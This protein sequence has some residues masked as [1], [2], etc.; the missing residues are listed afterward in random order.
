MVSKYSHAAFIIC[1]VPNICL[2]YCVKNFFFLVICCYNLQVKLSNTQTQC[3][4]ANYT[5]Y[6]IIMIIW[7]EIVDI[8]PSLNRNYGLEFGKFSKTYSPLET[9]IK[10]YFINNCTFFV[11]V[12]YDNQLIQI[13]VPI[14]NFPNFSLRTLNSG[15]NLNL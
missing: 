4:H 10:Y 11:V 14:F 5:N 8:K 13:K 7:Q 12:A 2:A 3:V 1:S 15:S 6:N 9:L